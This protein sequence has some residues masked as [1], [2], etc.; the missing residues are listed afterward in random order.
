MV[1]AHEKLLLTVEEA[2]ERLALGRT[3]V[4]AELRA[5]R[6]ESVRI[7]AARRVPADALAR[8]VERL[9]DEQGAAV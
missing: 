3:M 5:G 7:G 1:Q 6:L 2:A 4:Y 8:Y 9:R